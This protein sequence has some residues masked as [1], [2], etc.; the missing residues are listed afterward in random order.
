M[1]ET[2]MLLDNLERNQRLEQRIQDLEAELEGKNMNI[3]EDQKNNG[4]RKVHC[5]LLYDIEKAT[6]IHPWQN[7]LTEQQNGWTRERL[8]RTEK[9][10]FFLYGE[11]NIMGPY[12]NETAKF[13]KRPGDSIVPMDAEEALVWLEDHRAETEIILKYFADLIEE[14]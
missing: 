12:V 6:L 8:Y 3:Y 1:N 13:N 9:G 11:S 2:R 5:G 10:A 14:A 7:G 4:S